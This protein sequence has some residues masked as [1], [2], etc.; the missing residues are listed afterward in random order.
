MSRW[1]FCN[2]ISWNF[3]GMILPN[4]PWLPL[5]EEYNAFSA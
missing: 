1:K 2:R 3:M 5:K 4:I